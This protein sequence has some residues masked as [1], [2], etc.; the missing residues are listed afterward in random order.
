MRAQDAGGARAGAVDHVSARAHGEPTRGRGGSRMRV[1]LVGVAILIGGLG[2]SAYV[3]SQRSSSVSQANSRS[4]QTTAGDVTD[5]LA[6]RIDGSF[7]LTRMMRAIATMEPHADQ[8]RYARWYAQLGSGAIAG[9][10]KVNAV[11]IVPVRAAKLAAF[12]RQQMADPTIARQFGPGGFQ[13]LPAGRRASYCLERAV[14][15]PAASGSAYPVGLNYCAPEIP[16]FGPSPFL[17]L[18]RSVTDSGSFIV[19]PVAGITSSSL[20]GIGAAVYRSGAPTATVAQRRAAAIGYIATTLDTT[21]LIGAAL[22]GH[23]TLAITLYHAN[24]GGRLQRLA[25]GSRPGYHT[26]V[27]LGEGWVAQV[28]GRPANA[29]SATTQGLVVF[30]IGA[31]ITG[32]LFLLY[33]V[34]ALSRQRA[35]GL[36]GE[37]TVELEYRALHDPLT[38]LPN[39]HLVLD[40]A[41]QVLA[42]ARRMDV[43]VTVLFVDIDGF[44]GINDRF[45]HKTGDDVL[46][47]VAERLSGVLRESDT[48]GRLGGDEFVLVLD[49]T[50]SDAAHPDQVAERILTA[51]RKPLELPDAGPAPVAI[52]ASIGIASALADSAEDLLQH[53]DIAMY[54]AK[55]AGKG[56]YV[57]FEASMQAAIADRLNLELDL[58]DA[59]HA[60]QLYLDYQPVLNLASGE[61]VS[62]EALLRWQHPTRGVIAPDGF[63]PIAEASGMIAPIGR[64]V[65]EQACQQAASWRAKGHAIG[66]SV[67]ISPR[68]F[69][70][71]EF[72]E[73]VRSALDYSGLEPVWLT[74]EV[75]EAMLVRRPASTVALLGELKRV[76]VAIAVDDFGTGYSSLGYLRQFPIDAVK[77]D[78]SFVSELAS[79]AEADA[80]ARTLISLGKTLGIQTLAEGVE[81]DSQARQLRA[82]GCDLA[83]GFLFARP[84]APEALERFLEQ[85]QSSPIQASARR[86]PQIS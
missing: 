84:L 67:N 82:E 69:E 60:D 53:A 51:L 22:V 10:R 19:T 52:S 15:G 38:G 27:T 32:L 55:A 43:P 44:K 76:G 48:V 29:G 11:L 6:A 25:G 42:R 40:R 26:R 12:E 3:A 78:R 49:C 75:T 36:V 56:G 86:V 21:S 61:V 31:L 72:I 17:A 18:I 59:L 30:A 13:I 68:Q 20:V 83:Q 54:Q 7:N 28:S 62:A 24:P 35:W 2:A 81:E 70:R 63:I 57:V 46:R 50:G 39:R 8:R 9:F 58:A 80:L 85:G 4:F 16:G 37:K 23:G 47:H 73:E 14:V 41:S 33:R 64:W 45:G 79:S 5:T 66:V 77:I 71:P 34:L 74:L 1:L 65:L